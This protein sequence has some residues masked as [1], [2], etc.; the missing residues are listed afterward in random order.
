MVTFRVLMP[1]I[2]FWLDLVRFW[3]EKR[4]KFKIK[5]KNNR[6]MEKCILLTRKIELEK[7]TKSIEKKIPQKK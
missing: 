6:K 4:Q 5:Y 7:N 1:N 3:S 2:I